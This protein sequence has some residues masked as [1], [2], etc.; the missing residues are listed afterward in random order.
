MDEHTTN[1][2]GIKLGSKYGVLSDQILCFDQRFDIRINHNASKTFITIAQREDLIKDF[3]GQNIIYVTGIVGK[4]GVGKSTTLR[5]LR[6]LFI[7]DKK[8][9]DEREQDIV[10]FKD[11]G[12]IKVYINQYAR[13]DIEIDNETGLPLEEVY[14]RDY[15]K[16]LDRIKNLTTI[17]YSNSLET[18]FF[19]KESVN[20]YNVSTGFLK[21]QIG[22]INQA[23]RSK[24]IRTLG[25]VKR[26]RYTELKRQVEFLRAFNELQRRPDIPF[27]RIDAIAVNIHT[28]SR[29]DV[30]R[31]R[32]YLIENIE[33]V[34]DNM[35]LPEGFVRDL[36]DRLSATLSEFGKR[37]EFR[38]EHGTDPL[39]G[40]FYENLTLF[41]LR[42]IL[43]DNVLIDLL[44][45]QQEHFIQLIDI[46]REGQ[47][48]LD[49]DNSRYG[50]L[51]DNLRGL[52]ED[53]QRRATEKN[54]K[55]SKKQLPILAKL[56]DIE[57]LEV[58]FRR[59]WPEFEKD[60]HSLT[61]RTNSD[62]FSEFFERHYSTALDLPF[63]NMRWPSLSAGEESLIAYFSRL[64]AILKDIR[65]DNV[66]ML[67]D[68]GDLYFHPEWQRDYVHFLLE[69]LNS[70]LIRPNGIHLILTTHSPFIISDLPRENIIL[71]EKSEDDLGFSNVRVSRPEKRTLGGNIHTLFTENFFLG[72]STVS[73]FAR[74]KIQDEI[75]APIL[76]SDRFDI[77]KVQQ[78]IDRVGEPVLK[79]ILEERLSKRLNG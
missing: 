2:I 72:E 15:P 14:Y 37:I 21:E 63:M 28:L 38:Y 7:K 61:L 4:N 24:K 25:G 67:I 49:H 56:T 53:L 16:V 68:E 6:D 34:T 9:L 13:A 3:F 50:R 31:L 55:R 71:L 32:S 46:F 59:H 17:Y 76:S 54:E 52:F 29:N 22:K 11:G 27:K 1:L 48:F 45:Q 70:E 79:R 42:S 36:S 26:F 75:I 47:E 73:S 23:V 43:Q 44:I 8:E 65:S 30:D 69:F 64:F 19:E 10:F 62:L 74:Q 77:R 33:R 18:D 66:L 58:Y 20:Y 60:K 39:Q 41:L 5:Y 35:S 51:I 40:R 12:V 78:L 57:A